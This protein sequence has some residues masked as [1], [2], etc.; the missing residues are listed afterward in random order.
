MQ[1]LLLA[2]GTR[3]ELRSLLRPPAGSFVRFKPHNDSFLD[4]AARQVTKQPDE[5]LVRRRTAGSAPE[6]HDDHDH[7]NS[8]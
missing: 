7:H 5:A 3:I 1:N 8:G 2:E 4:V 6:H